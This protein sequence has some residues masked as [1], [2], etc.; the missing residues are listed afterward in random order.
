MYPDKAMAATS[1]PTNDRT[2][3]S[4]RVESN[5]N[6]D[7][8]K[9]RK[10]IARVNIIEVLLLRFRWPSIFDSITFINFLSLLQHEFSETQRSSCSRNG[11]IR[12]QIM[13]RPIIIR[14]NSRLRTVDTRDK[15]SLMKP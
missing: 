1:A 11:N 6:E 15:L 5:S 13:D 14:T 3:F 9:I 4:I 12:T 2:D 8:A 10:D 7:A